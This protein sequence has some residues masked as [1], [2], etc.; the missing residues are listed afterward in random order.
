MEGSEKAK[1][2]D[3]WNA[4]DMAA[5]AAPIKSPLGADRHNPSCPSRGRYPLQPFINTL[6]LTPHSPVYFLNKPPHLSH[7]CQD[8]TV[9]NVVIPSSSLSQRWWGGGDCYHSRSC[10]AAH[11]DIPSSFSP[12][13]PFLPLIHQFPSM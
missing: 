10:S 5:A 3:H 1:R 4:G 8:Y 7:L 13:P 2:A 6:N 12:F 11:S 9:Q